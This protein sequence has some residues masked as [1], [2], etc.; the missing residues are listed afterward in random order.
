M[1]AVTHHALTVLAELFICISQTVQH[2]VIDIVQR[3]TRFKVGAQHTPGDSLPQQLQG[4]SAH[5][6]GIFLTYG[7]RKG[8]GKEFT[9]LLDGCHFKTFLCADTDRS[10]A[11]T[12]G[13]VLTVGKYAHHNKPALHNGAVRGE[14][15]LL[16]IFPYNLVG[17]RVQ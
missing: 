11:H 7:F 1:D 4:A 17:I 13:K 2:P 15:A 6:A 14:A 8:K 12:H 5:A 10:N 16:Y 9:L 3:K